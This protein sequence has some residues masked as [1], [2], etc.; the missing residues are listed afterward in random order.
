MTTANVTPQGEQVTTLLN[1]AAPDFELLSVGGKRISLQAYRG[2]NNIILWF[3]R[4]FQCNFCRSYMENFTEGYEQLQANQ[5]EVIQVAPNLYNSAQI[6]FSKRPPPRYPFICDPDKRLYAVYRLGDRGVLD[7]T[8]NTA[9]TFSNALTTGEMLETMYGSWL[10]IANR[11]FL[12][13]LHHHAFTAVEQGLF[14]IDRQG[15]IRH[16]QIVS[17]IEPVPTV[18]ELLPLIHALD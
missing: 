9:V 16:R 14:L 12:R 8:R 7:A 18:S 5:T 15:I 4:G 11:N 13:R 17:P 6:Y 1:Q 10:D 2:E 3:S